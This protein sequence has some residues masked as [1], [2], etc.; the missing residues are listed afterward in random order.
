M[1]AP[2]RAHLWRNLGESHPDLGSNQTAEDSNARECIAPA[3][4][5]SPRQNNSSPQ[6]DQAQATNRGEDTAPQVRRTTR[7][8]AQPPVR[9]Q[10]LNWQV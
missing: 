10:D 9:Y 8:K 5:A 6:V 3:G 1:R 4:L 7:S 2:T